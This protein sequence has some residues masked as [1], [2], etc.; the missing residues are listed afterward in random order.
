M[1]GEERKRV[2]YRMPPIPKHQKEI[3]FACATLYADDDDDDA[4]D[5]N[6]GSKR[7]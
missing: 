6:D 3:V 2:R 5:D 4:D 7:Y 1:V